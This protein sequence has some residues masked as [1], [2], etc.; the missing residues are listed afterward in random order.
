M[1][2]R[3]PCEANDMLMMDLDFHLIFVN[4]GMGIHSPTVQVRNFELM[5]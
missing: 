3:Y 4:L 2:A 1:I 5:A